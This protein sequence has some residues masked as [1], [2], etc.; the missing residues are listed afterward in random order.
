MTSLGYASHPPRVVAVVPARGGSRGVPGKNLREVG[1]VSL[2][3]RAI[4]SALCTE[5][6]DR[7]VVSTDDDRIDTAATAEGADV[8]LRPFELSG[9][10]ASSEA[11]VLHAVEA[12]DWAVDVLVFLQAT[13]PFIRPSDLDGAIERVVSGECDVVFSAVP[14]HVFLWR[15]GGDGVVGV[16]HD[17]S[18]RVRRQDRE[19]EYLETGAFYVM[20]A[21][22]FRRA[23]SRFFGQVGI[24]EVAPW[25]AVEIDSET[26]LQLARALAPTLDRR[27]VRATDTGVPD[28]SITLATTPERN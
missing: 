22:G 28:S 5:H 1:G 13:S 3:A 17:A 16:N 6:I 15:Q 21:A 7:V 4:G 20:D 26:D 19:P 25:T 23:G 2:I 14:S 9:D 8:V 10:T 18:F 12:I 11:A 27:A 24:A